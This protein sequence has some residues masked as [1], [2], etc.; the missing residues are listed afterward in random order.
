V[1]GLP[2]VNY[3]HSSENNYSHESS[4]NRIICLLLCFRLLSSYS[5]VFLFM[6]SSAYLAF[7]VTYTCIYP[8]LVAPIRAISYGALSRRGI[9][10]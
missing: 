2:P 9:C 4:R 7:E 5:S 3:K 10:T 6:V 8:L 1:H